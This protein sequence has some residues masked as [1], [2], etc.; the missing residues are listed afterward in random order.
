VDDVT[1]FTYVGNAVTPTGGT[2]DEVKIRVRKAHAAFIQ[3]YSVWKAKEVSTETKMWIFS[4]NV[5]SV[6]LYGCETW[7]LTKKILNS[8]QGFINKCLRRLLRIF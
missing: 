3:L 1:E 2:E 4:S 8:L 6:L 5:K 7:K